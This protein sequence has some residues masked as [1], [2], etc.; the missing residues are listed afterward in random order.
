MNKAE[1][2]TKRGFLYVANHIK[3][4]K[5]AE[6]SVKSLK[7]WNA[8]P[9]CLITSLIDYKSDLFD[10]ILIAEEVAKYSYASKIFGLLKSPFDNIVFLDTDTFVCGNIEN[11][12]D[13]LDH[14]DI[15]AAH[16]NGRHKYPRGTTYTPI[17]EHCFPELNTG[18]IVLNKARCQSFLT[19]WLSLFESYRER[20]KSNF[21]QFS[22]RDALLNSRLRIATLPIEY[23]FRGLPT[24][25]IAY[26][27]VHIIHDRLRYRWN[28]LRPVMDDFDKMIKY[29]ARLNRYQGKRFVVSGVGIIP[30][31]YAPNNVIRKLKAMLGIRQYKKRD[32]F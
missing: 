9:T 27:K 25:A 21:N 12:F 20:Y 31:R 18:V 1:G 10:Q 16:E 3:Y 32:S 13:I 4:I 11:L 15:A 26:S 8:G 29:A 22:F 30:Y 2:Y 23:N 17:L 19:E 14:F 6:V 5:E 28:N 7:L 24:G